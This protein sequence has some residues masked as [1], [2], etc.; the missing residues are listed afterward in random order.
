MKFNMLFRFQFGF[1]PKIEV[2]ITFINQIVSAIE[3][4]EIVIGIF[5]DF[6]KAFTKLTI[7]IYYRNYINWE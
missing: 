1:V 2:F 4:G 7:T 5:L 6:K 3:K